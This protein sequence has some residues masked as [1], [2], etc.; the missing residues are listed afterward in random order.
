MRWTSAKV[1]QLLSLEIIKQL[2]QLSLGRFFAKV[3]DTA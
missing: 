2:Q 3:N 1:N